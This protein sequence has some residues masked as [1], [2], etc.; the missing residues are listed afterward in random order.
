LLA[1]RGRPNEAGEVSW[2]RVPALECNQDDEYRA[3][4]GILTVLKLIFVILAK[5]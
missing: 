1:F 5:F 3:D 4:D 2:S